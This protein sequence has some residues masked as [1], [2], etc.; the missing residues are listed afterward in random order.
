MERL[1][2]NAIKASINS[3]YKKKDRVW[4]ADCIEKLGEYEDLEEQGLLLRMPCKVGDTVYVI[5]FYCSKPIVYEAIVLNVFI[6]GENI[7]FN[8]K[9]DEFEI[10]VRLKSSKFGKTVFLTKE[11]A[12]QALRQIGE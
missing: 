2:Q 5:G 4:T 11:E 9:V 12:E 3:K 10:N 8:A 1:T 7:E 6:F